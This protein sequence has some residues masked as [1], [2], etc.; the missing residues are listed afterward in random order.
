[1]L[2][3]DV[4]QTK[5]R[6]QASMAAAT[7]VTQNAQA[8]V[9]VVPILTDP[10]DWFV[11]IQND[12]LKS[13]DHSNDWLNRICPAVNGGIPAQLVTFNHA[14]QSSSSPILDVLNAAGAGASLTAD[15]RGTVDTALAA[16]SGA[17]AAQ[18]QS[19]LSLLA[20]IKSYFVTLAGDQ[21]A[22]QAD[23]GIV[24][25][26]FA[27]SHVW[28][29]EMSAA[30]GE[31]FLESNV[32][33]PCMAIVQIDEHVQLQLGGIGTDPTLN[34]LVLAKAILQNQAA[35]DGTTLQAVQAVLDSWTTL[36]VKFEAVIADLKDAASDDRYL[37]VLTQLDLATART[38]WQQLADFANGLTNPDAADDVVAAPSTA[39]T[40]T[41]NRRTSMPLQLATNVKVQQ[42]KLAGYL[43]AK[44]NVAAYVG[45]LQSTDISGVNFDALPADIKPPNDPAALLQVVN[46]HLATAKQHGLTWSSS[47]QPGLTSIPQ[48]IIN[49]NATFQEAVKMLLSLV[50]DLLTDPDT[51]PD[52]GKKRDLVIQLFGALLQK[53]AEQQKNVTS[54]FA[55]VRQ[56]NADVT[57][58]HGNFTSG[59]NQ[60]AIIRQFE[61]DERD[62]L[63]DAIKDLNDTIDT[64]N[65]QITGESIGVAGGG[66]LIGVGVIAIATTGESGVGAVVGAVCI[67]VG[68]LAGGL[69]AGFLVGAINA[70][71]AAEKQKSFDQM[72]V[73]E[74]TIQMQA[75]D[76]TESVLSKLV[77]QSEEAIASVQVI[78]DV[79]AS[80][81]AKIQAV[82]ADLND[83]EQ[84][85]GNILSVLDLQTA[86]DQWAQLDTF[87]TQMQEFEKVVFGPAPIALQLDPVSVKIK[88]TSAS[89]SAF[90]SAPPS[91][92]A[93]L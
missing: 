64:L 61:S 92:V 86:Q 76:T 9:T 4:D 79:W 3:T 51:D 28:I 39:F 89:A 14:F 90:T 57:T 36:K 84:A 27:D 43:N 67:V 82:I 50:Q 17:V 12:L 47:I 69:S 52:K 40:T 56:F 13:Q 32:L 80:L 53:I 5:A 91:A 49:Y 60:F 41:M 46:A 85:I 48:A 29:Q 20:T 7:A 21:D 11:P 10:P 83:S 73:D 23:L 66:V 8:T 45:A 1:M 44:A 68:L 19:V 34:A 59:N 55:L 38:Q 24:T 15:Q 75:L 54:E 33:G 70:R 65:K 6:V 78:L 2:S 37:A 81:Q 74:L 18:E 93:A 62:N 16:L 63:R 31:T 26:Q 87:A 42:D 88:P 25:Q 22:L 72:E 71:S 77:T 30:M 58:D 35:N